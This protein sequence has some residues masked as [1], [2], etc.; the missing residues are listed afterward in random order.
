[1]IY[2]ILFALIIVIGIGVEI[3][4][5]LYIKRQ[6]REIK[7]LETELEALETERNELRKGK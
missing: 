3:S 5:R 1:M 4:M 2:G 6:R 7:A